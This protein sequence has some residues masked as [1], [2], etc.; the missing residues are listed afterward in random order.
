MKSDCRA[1]FTLVELLIVMAVVAVLVAMLVPLGSEAFDRG[2]MAQCQ[3]NLTRI[4]EAHGLWRTAHRTS[5]FAVGPD[6]IGAIMPYLENR[7][8]VLK[9]P[10]AEETDYTLTAFSAIKLSDIVFKIYSGGR[11]LYDI[12]CDAPFIFRGEQPASQ[13]PEW[14]E[15]AIEDQQTG[16]DYRSDHSDIVVEF[17][18]YAGYPAEI[19]FSPRH[20]GHGYSFELEIA[21][22]FLGHYDPEWIGEKK[23]L[24]PYATLTAD[25]GMSLG[26][27]QVAGLE[28]NVPDGKLFFICDYPKSLADYNEDGREEDET[29]VYFIT[30]PAEWERRR[31]GGGGEWAYIPPELSWRHYQSLRHFGRANVLF[32]D[33][34]V[35]P[36]GVDP[37]S[38]ERLLDQ[39]YLR[40]DSALWRW[41]ER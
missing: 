22:E 7:N 37:D 29:D 23:D 30:D 24:T 19:Y 4:Y 16:G 41:G 25:Y 18:F 31:Q 8:E 9:C 12:A 6:W 15:F 21:G 34:H 11:H 39:K 32:C 26:C 3:L 10:A 20:S 36:L 14:V 38:A 17:R 5:Q 33:G 28:P 1:A 35:E 40:A 27:Y 13:G 2:K